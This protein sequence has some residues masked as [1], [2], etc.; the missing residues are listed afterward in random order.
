MIQRQQS[1]FICC[2]LNLAVPGRCLLQGASLE[3]QQAATAASAAA[4]AIGSLASAADTSGNPPS[5]PQARPEL[6]Q[7]LVERLLPL[8]SSLTGRELLA[9]L[10]QIGQMTGWKLASTAISGAA[11][12]MK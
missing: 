10:T 7:M 6:L 12:S 11:A 3:Q 1:L 5:H 8:S 2:G 4:A 9:A